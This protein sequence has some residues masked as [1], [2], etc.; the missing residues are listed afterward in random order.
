MNDTVVGV[1]VG[2]VVDRVTE[3]PRQIGLGVAEAVTPVGAGLTLRAYVVVLVHP[4]L[5][6]VYVIVA[7]PVA[8]PDAWK[9]PELEVEL[10][11]VTPALLLVHVPPLTVSFNV[12]VPF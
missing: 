1:V 10:C 12:T 8:E 9:V 11:N 3:D 6:T 5:V 2:P 4:P 7:I